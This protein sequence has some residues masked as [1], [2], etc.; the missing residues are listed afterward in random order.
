MDREAKQRSSNHAISLSLARSPIQ[1]V[2]ES[3]YCTASAPC[4][5]LHMHASS[6]VMPR[7]AMGSVD[8]NSDASNG[9]RA[10]I[11]VTNIDNRG[12]GMQGWRQ[13][14]FSGVC[15]CDGLVM[16]CASAF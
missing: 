9:K 11:R 15:V 1:T 5:L 3:I 2:D 8:C 16:C 6:D 12:H 4:L 14:E 7:G 13:G 10:S